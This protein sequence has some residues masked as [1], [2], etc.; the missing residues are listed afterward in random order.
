[1]RYCR[2]TALFYDADSWLFG[3]IPFLMQPFSFQENGESAGP[4]HPFLSV[5]GRPVGSILHDL[6]ALSILEL[7]A[8]SQHVSPHNSALLGQ[9][10]RAGTMVGKQTTRKAGGNG[11]SRQ[12]CGLIQLPAWLWEKRAGHGHGH[13]HGHALESMHL[14]CSHVCSEPVLAL[15]GSSSFNPRKVASAGGS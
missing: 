14:P 5:A 4:S 3:A 9:G 8:S 7:S 10:G 6:T 11:A 1:M 2:L 12:G 13:G 15:P